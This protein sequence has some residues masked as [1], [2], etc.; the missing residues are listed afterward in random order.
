MNDILLDDFFA[1]SEDYLSHY[2]VGHLDGG[3]SG[4]YPWGSGEDGYQRYSGFLD[5]YNKYVAEGKTKKEIAEI[6]GITDRWGKPYVRALDARV[7]NA[8]AEQRMNLVL[9][10]R[11]L[12]DQGMGPTEIGRIM[13]KNESSIR[14]LLDEGKALRTNR[15][16]K[17]SETLKDFVD[18]N[19]YVDIG[20]GAEQALGLTRNS[21][22][23]ALAL[24]A[25]QGYQEQE[26]LMENLGTDHK[27]TMTV[28]TPPDVS[29]G[30]LSEH[31]YDIVNLNLNNTSRTLDPDDSVGALGIR[32]RVDVDSKRVA[33]LYN[34]EGGKEKDG[35]IEIR[36][37]VPDLALGSSDYA[38]VRIP[39]D[40]THYIKGMAIYNPNLPPGVDILVNSN[41]HLGTPLKGM[42]D[43]SVLKPMKGLN[44]KTLEGTPD[45]DNPYGASVTQLSWLDANG[46]KHDSSINV[47]HEEGEY[48]EWSRNLAS[49]FLS[50]Q[51]VPLAHR[52][53]TMDYNDK[54]QEFEEICAL[55]NPTIKKK[56]LISYADN[57]DAAAVELKA[58]PFPGQQF[59]V[60]IPDP[61][62]KDNEIFAP[63]YPDGTRVALIRYPHGGK[64]EIAECTVRNTGS[65][66]AELIGKNA[67]DAVCINHNVA[68]RLSGADFDGDT[69]VVIPQSEKVRISTQ[70]PLRGLE[71]FDTQEAYPGYEGMKVLG[72]KQKQTEMGKVSNLI[73]DM[74]LKGANDD[75]LAA[76]VRHSMVIIDAEKHELNWQ[77]S[78]KDNRIAELKKLYQGKAAENDETEDGSGGAGTIISRAKGQYRVDQRK[79]WSPSEK[80]ID[81]VTGE[82]IYEYTNSTYQ[83]VK[84][85]G[86]KVKDGGRVQINKTKEG[87]YYYLKTDPDTGKKVRVSVTEEDFDGPIRTVKRQERSTKMAEEKDAFK[88]TSGGSKENYGYEMEYEYA[89][90]ANNMKA[91]GNAARKEW[92]KTPNLKMDPQAKREYSEEVKSLNAKLLNAESNAPIERQAQRNANRTI[93]LKKESNPNIDK[94]DLRKYKQQAIEAERQRLGAKKKKRLIEIT[95]REWEA[96]QAGAI[97][98]SKLRKIL[99][100]TDQDKL[101]KRAT[102]RN[103]R[104]ISDTM[105]ALAKN[106]AA[107]GYTSAQIADRLGISASSVYGILKGKAE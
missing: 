4:R 3:H 100:N 39:V 44:K 98:D 65:P 9:R 79:D 62:L 8:K 50:K 51:P 97:S 85:K 67:P 5:E 87:G 78:E 25:D 35:L 56:L 2:G 12:A 92:L 29:Y 6:M 14:T 10:A 22:K 64:F 32:S 69:V 93:A 20:P 41:K 30:E 106:M 53:L 68:S 23:N 104:A 71:G 26:I 72:A 76:A 75:D 37:G 52:Q 42:G 99:D 103:T 47:V 95:D 81:P 63:N 94:A 61:R 86:I 49:Q 90:Y 107:S 84:L 89:T 105:K 60:I 74:T 55:T 17:A 48:R 19:K 11:E 7:S 54:K 33:V 15:Y 27:T 34:E 16:R 59:H 24:L 96:I 91:L 80:S 38:Q 102:P 13:G 31:R 82:K 1:E 83:E 57:C 58:A 73:T 70:K 28:L 21:F 36:P 43:D 101:R 66:S 46:V 77:K 18:E 88:L 45:P 40:G